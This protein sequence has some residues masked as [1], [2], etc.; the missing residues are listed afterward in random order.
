MTKKPR[1]TLCRTDWL[2]AAL[3]ALGE[4]GVEAIKVLPLATT[5][6]A[7]RGSFYWHFRDRDDLLESVLAHWEDTLTDAVIERAA[8]IDDDAPNRLMSLMEDVLDRRR[9]RH[10][11]AIRAWALYDPAAAKVVRRVDR[12]RITFIGALFKDMGFSQDQSEARAH[13]T[14]AYLLGDHQ[15]F[16]QESRENRRKHLRSRHELLTR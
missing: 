11:P 15:V 9:G 4:G 14:Y 6:K 1:E 2:A 7:S 5:L 12:K 8:S 16:M 10:D 13:L 3:R